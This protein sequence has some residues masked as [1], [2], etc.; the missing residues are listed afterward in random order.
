MIML[1]SMMSLGFVEAVTGFF[2]GRM[3]LLTTTHSPEESLLEKPGGHVLFCW[4][5]TIE[6]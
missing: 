6:K 3:P 2:S 1:V 5:G 4:H